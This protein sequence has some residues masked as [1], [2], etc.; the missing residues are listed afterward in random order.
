MSTAVILP[1][2]HRAEGPARLRAA[3]RAGTPGAVRRIATGL[4]L[5]IAA[6]T[7][8]AAL[9]V[10][11]AQPAQA[12]PAEW[13]AAERAQYER[14][15]DARN[16][17]ILKT[18][19]SLEGTPYRY[20]G[21]SPSSGFDCSGFTSYVYDQVGIG[22]PRTSSAQHD[23]VT[24]I[25]QGS[26]KPGDLVFFHGSGGV[27]HVAIYAGNDKVWHAPNSGGSVEMVDIWDSSITFGR[28]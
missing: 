11:A 20:G 21:S 16:Y 15:I 5:G 24:Q 4:G 2:R 6:V 19:Q 23:A 9:S 22:L 25:S 3:R 13:S 18:A 10:G 1:P 17:Q 7:S 27:Y 8:T 14:D 12:Y 28:A 26:A